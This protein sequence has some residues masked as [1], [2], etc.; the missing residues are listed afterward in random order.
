MI[1]GVGG[2]CMMNGRRKSEEVKCHTYHVWEQAG[3]YH[4]TLGNRT[5]DMQCI[6][7]RAKAVKRTQLP[8]QHWKK[9]CA[10]LARPLSHAHHAV[11]LGF[12]HLL[13]VPEGKCACR[14]IS[15]QMALIEVCY[16]SGC[17]HA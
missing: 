6:T 12:H 1:S 3:R 11:P 16:A 4:G 14:R 10:H 13:H 15:C 2:V 8:Q 7:G 5:Q 9:Q 17:V